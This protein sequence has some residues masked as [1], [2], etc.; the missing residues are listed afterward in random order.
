MGF[1]PS[2]DVEMDKM[3]LLVPCLGGNRGLGLG[4]PSGQIFEWASRSLG[5]GKDP[6]ACLCH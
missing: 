6:W 4:L 5:D 2:S 3:S 1:T